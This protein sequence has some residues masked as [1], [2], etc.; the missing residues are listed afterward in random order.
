MGKRKNI[1]CILVIQLTKQ[2][3]GKRKFFDVKYWKRNRE[4][5]A[6][7]YSNFPSQAIFCP[8]KSL[9]SFISESQQHFLGISKF[10]A[11]KYLFLWIFYAE[12]KAECKDYF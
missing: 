5:Q 10:Y 8:W 9:F 1:D 11:R 12:K 6:I 2:Q 4:R 7:K 3:A